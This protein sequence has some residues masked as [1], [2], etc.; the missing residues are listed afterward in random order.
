MS[1][2]QMY[3]KKGL[4]VSGTRLPLYISKDFLGLG[5]RKSLRGTSLPYEG[6]RSNYFMDNKTYQLTIS[7]SPI[8]G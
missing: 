7:T 1:N 8:P 6:P 5:I 3:Q 4:P 2:E